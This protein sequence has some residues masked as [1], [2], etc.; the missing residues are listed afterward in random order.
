MLHERAVL[1]SSM[2]R[3]GRLWGEPDVAQAALEV[4]PTLSLHPTWCV[5]G[6]CSRKWDAT[7]P[8]LLEQVGFCVG[9]A[10]KSTC[11]RCM[12]FQRIDE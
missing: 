12:R 10:R 9:S 11:N 7:L 5:V 3:D 1:L 8:D 2:S 6:I 4:G